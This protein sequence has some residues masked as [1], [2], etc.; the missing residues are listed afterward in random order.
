[1][2]G[3]CAQLLKA[4]ERTILMGP[5]SP[6]KPDG[7]EQPWERGIPGQ[8]GAQNATPPCPPQMHLTSLR[9]LFSGSLA[10]ILL[11]QWG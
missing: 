1:M 7:I 9:L 11:Q 10:G 6:C 4:P 3:V 8:N 5:V 2:L